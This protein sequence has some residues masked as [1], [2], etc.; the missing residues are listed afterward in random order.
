MVQLGV[1]E[2]NEI[3]QGTGLKRTRGWVYMEYIYEVYILPSN[4]TTHIENRREQVGVGS[5]SSVLS[6]SHQSEGSSSR[7]SAF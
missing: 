7:P 2:V 4:K 5:I 3:I 6:A 1:N